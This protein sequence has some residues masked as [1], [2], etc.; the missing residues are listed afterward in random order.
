MT[1]GD[2]EFMAAHPSLL[3]LVVAAIQPGD[4]P[5]EWATRTP[6]LRM[7]ASHWGDQGTRCASRSRCALP[8]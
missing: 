6:A 1:D 5:L 2:Q 7:A 8:S 4:N 3:E